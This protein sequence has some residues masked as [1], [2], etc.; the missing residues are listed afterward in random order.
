LVNRPL[1]KASRRIG[2][3][4]LSELQR[5]AARMLGLG[6]TQEATA[7][8]VGVNVRTVKAWKATI[9]AFKTAIEAAQ[10][11]A[12]DPTV[13]DVLRDM[14]NHHDPRVRLEASKELRAWGRPAEGEGD[15]SGR[16]KLIVFD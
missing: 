9:P 11:D 16:G 3:D 6:H 12:A 10:D 8:W 4:G 7:A 5:R 14:L 13:I 15:T 1:P 2:K